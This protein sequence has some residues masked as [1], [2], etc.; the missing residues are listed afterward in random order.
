VAGGGARRAIKSYHRIGGAASAAASSKC[1]ARR[2]LLPVGGRWRAWRINNHR[3]KSSRHQAA[4]WRQ[5]RRAQQR[6]RKQRIKHHRKMANKAWR[7]GISI[8]I[9][10]RQRIT[11]PGVGA[12]QACLFW[13]TLAYSDTTSR[14]P[15]LRIAGYCRCDPP[16]GVFSLSPYT[17]TTHRCHGVFPPPVANRPLLSS[18]LLLTDFTYRSQPG[19]PCCGRVPLPM[20]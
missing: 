11:H 12:C 13:M 2:C 8:I 10:H 6:R 16:G 14:R 7:H 18:P 15:P 3:R 1:W 9:K 20:A 19:L 17:Y 4:A 5:W